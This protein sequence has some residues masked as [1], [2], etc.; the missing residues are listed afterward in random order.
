MIPNR[1]IRL[2]EELCSAAERKFLHR[3]GSLDE[4]VATL[5]RE[6]V[7]DDAVLMDEQEQRVVEERLKGLG[8]I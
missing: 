7:R 5:L 8:Y 6:M 2:P 1:T 3:F 4:F